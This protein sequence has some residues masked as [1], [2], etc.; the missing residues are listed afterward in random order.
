[1]DQRNIEAPR[2]QSRLD[3]HYLT[4]VLFKKISKSFESAEH[5]TRASY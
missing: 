4:T 2:L 3:Q 1:V 5:R